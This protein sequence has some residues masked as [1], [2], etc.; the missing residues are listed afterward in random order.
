MRF[1]RKIHSRGVLTLPFDVRTACDIN[2]GDLVEFEIKR[3]VRRDAATT[4]TTAVP[5]VS[6]LSSSLVA[7][8]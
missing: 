8:T 6:S 7:T 3:V 4:T 2:E 5:P 1:V